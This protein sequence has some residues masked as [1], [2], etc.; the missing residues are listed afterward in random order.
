MGPCVVQVYQKQSLE[1]RRQPLQ[2]PLPLL[3]AQEPSEVETYQAELF[4]QAQVLP[5]LVSL[6]LVGAQVAVDWCS[7]TTSEPVEEE[8]A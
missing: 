4:L 3:F 2:L 8:I 5:D 6:E 1:R 7:G